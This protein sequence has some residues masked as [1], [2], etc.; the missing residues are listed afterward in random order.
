[1][2]EVDP[3]PTP[4]GVENAI[5]D[6]A[7][8]AATAD[9]SLDVNKR[10]HLEYFNR[11][12]SRIFSEG[13]ESE[14][15]LKGGTGILSRVPSSRSTATSTS[16]A[17]LHPVRDAESRHL[18]FCLSEFVRP[19]QRALGQPA[20]RAARAPQDSHSGAALDDLEPIPSRVQR[21]G[22]DQKWLSLPCPMRIPVRRDSQM[23]VGLQ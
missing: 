23:L 22:V 12:L 5:K 19:K 7:K 2:A 8:K 21:P 6:A 9:P 14:W 18:R 17:G 13:E 10:I 3:Y 20:G 16:T 11:F 1:M 15:V 4:G